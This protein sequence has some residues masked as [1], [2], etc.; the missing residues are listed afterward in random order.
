[1]CE[2]AFGP[3]ASSWTPVPAVL[4]DLLHRGLHVA[5]ERRVDVL[6][7][8]HARRRVRNVDERGR[9]AVDAVQRLRHL[10]GDVQQLRAPLRPKGDLPH[11]GILRAVPSPPTPQELDAF[12]AGTDRF[13]AELDEE[14][15][16]HYGGL[17]E[18]L[19][20]EPIYERHA[21]LTELEQA[22][23]LGAA[24][25]GDRG[26]RE[27]W[28]FACEG[29]LGKLTRAHAE[30]LA[31]LEAELEVTIDG[32]TVPFRML[33]PTMANEPDRAK[34]ERIDRV[35]W[36]TTEEHLNPLYLEAVEETRAALPPLGASTLPRALRA[37]RPQAGRP[38][39]AVPRVP[40]VDRVAVRAD[41]RP[42]APRA[43]RDRARRGEA[44]G[45]PAHDPLAAVGRELPGRPDAP[46]PA[47]DARR[48]RDRPRQPGERPPRHRA[49][50]ARSPRAPSA[51]RSR[52]P[53]R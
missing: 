36:E 45:R 33:R 31:A 24:V 38:C 41:R 3:S 7:D 19:E 6:V 37:I 5:G 14:F 47:R 35:M 39:R 49:A 16:L 1:M 25:N 18:R 46:G 32:E 42:R 34:R 29:Y 4:D 9:G 23:S 52:C 10:G 2:G 21:D 51:R 11:G 13:I 15:Y 48:P 26:I 50:A 17:K 8:R 20:L 22:Q 28:R 43:A 12:R 40:R 30:K 44:V 53:T 27:L